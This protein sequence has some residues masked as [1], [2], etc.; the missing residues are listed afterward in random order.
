MSEK[1]S[2]SGSSDCLRV[3]GIVSSGLGKS[4]L[5]TEIPWVKRQFRE[6]LGID[7]VPGTLNIIVLSEDRSKLVDIKNMKGIGI[8]PEE[9]NYCAGESFIVSI[10]DR[11]SGALVI[12]KVPDYPA[13]QLE[14]ISSEHIKQTLKLKDGDIVEIEIRK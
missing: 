8:V 2:K 3:R 6:K 7:P 9:K 13:E 5:F 11:V 1:K 10:N 12:P 14:I 4:F